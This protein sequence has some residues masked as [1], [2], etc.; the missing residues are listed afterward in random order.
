MS[1]RLV[2]RGTWQGR[3]AAR[4][5]SV[6]MSLLLALITAQPT[7]ASYQGD[8]FQQ[9][10]ERRYRLEPGVF[11]Y[12]T[13]FV[14]PL[15]ELFGEIYVGDDVFVAANS[16]LRAAPTRQIV[17]GTGSSVQDNVII[18]A[19][20]D[21]IEIGENATITH[22]AIVRNS[23]IGSRAY[24]GYRATITDARIGDGAVIWHGAKVEGVNI[25]S[26]AFVGAGRVITSQS[27]ADAL[28]K[29]PAEDKEYTNRRLQS[30]QAFARGYINL[31][32]TEGYEAVIGLS[33]NPR[34]SILPQTTEPSI[35]PDVEL[36]EFVRIVGDVRVGRNSS[37]GQRTTIRADEGSPIIIGAGANI[38]D[39]V[40]F[41]GLEDTDVRIGDNL[42]VD[43]DAVIHGPLSVGNNVTV[44][45]GTVVFNAT[46][47]DNVEIGNH[48]IVSTPPGEDERIVIPASSVVPDGAIISGP[49][50]LKKLGQRGSDDED[51][52]PG[53][54]PDTGYGG[55]AIGHA[56]AFGAAGA[57]PTGLEHAT[58]IAH[59]PSHR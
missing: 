48:V 57:M 27:Q 30:N 32:Q 6:M 42:T 31:Y 53:Q 22:H 41:H 16:I 3:R 13:G 55:G 18:R 29:V 26:N 58:G 33:R 4:V 5:A 46:V 10:A 39:R 38:D 15:A 37:I 49:D 52:V 19:L 24:I 45:E 2:V 12:G 34:T 25:P 56:A 51:D 17:V 23:Q 40:T 44:G 21:S 1:E 59:Q 54:L 9:E 28:P 11:V 7:L 20:E 50:D 14:A 36:Q 47:G 35:A 8:T 43:D